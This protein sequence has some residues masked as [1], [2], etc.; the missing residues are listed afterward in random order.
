MQKFFFRKSGKMKEIWRKVLENSEPCSKTLEKEKFSQFRDFSNFFQ[1][2][3]KFRLLYFFNFYFLYFSR[4]HTILTF[5]HVP[6]N[7]DQF[8]PEIVIPMLVPIFLVKL[9]RRSL[10]LTWAFNSKQFLSDCGPFLMVVK[11]SELEWKWSAEEFSDLEK[12]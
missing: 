7:L 2:C 6:K 12:I 4:F 5:S 3:P 8:F 10:F 11:P 1:A 9:T